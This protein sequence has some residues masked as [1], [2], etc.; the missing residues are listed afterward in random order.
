MSFLP[1][2]FSAPLA[3]IGLALLPVIYYLLR[4]T[5]PRPRQIPFPPLKLI[6]DIEPKDETPA[7]TPWWL[8]ALRLAIAALIVLAMAGPIWNPQ[9]GGAD[10]KEPLLVLLDDSWA[11]APT[12]EQRLKVAL[13]QVD[14]AARQGAPTAVVTASEG[15]R[16][17]VLSDASHTAQKLRALK[18]VPFLPDRMNLVAPIE[19]FFTEHPRGHLTWISD[20]LASGQTRPFAEKLAELAKNGEVEIVNGERSP[21]ALAGAANEASVLNVNVL[22]A[23]NDGPQQGRVRALDL[24]GVQIG[25][26]PFAFGNATETQARFDLPIE[27][28]NDIARLEIAGER[29]AGAVT[30]LDERWKRRRVGIVSGATADVAQPLLAPSYYLQRALQPFADVRE[31]RPGIADPIG[32]LLDDNVNVMVLAD[33]GVVAGLAHD[34]LQSFIEDGGA[35]VRFA[36]TRLAGSSDDLVPVALRRGG[37]TLGGSLSWDTPKKLAPFDR[38]SPF[39]GLAVPDEVTV[40]RQVL[41]E[42]EAGLPARTWAALADGTPLVT[43]E[44]QGK[45]MLVLFHVT[46]DTTWSNLPLSGLFVDMLRKILAISADTGKTDE[47][48]TSAAKQ[49]AATLAPLS[50]LDGFGALGPPPS[51][52]KPIPANFTDV[53][54]ADH[55]PGFYGPPDALVAVNP[56]ALDAKLQAADFSGLNFRREPL[57]AGEP[58]DL[59]PW[60]IA[61][62]I[63]LLI[64]DALASLFLSGGVPLRRQRRAAIAGLVALFAFG[65]ATMPSFV[66]PARAE[67]RA[68]QISPRDLESA[69]TTRL[70]YVVTGDAQADEA[71]RAG[72][73]SLTRALA[74][75][76]SLTPGDPVGVDPARDELVFYPLIYWPVVAGKPLPPQNAINKI[77]T[78]MKQGGTII[79]DTRDALASRPGGPMTPEARWLRDLLAGVDVPELEPVPHDHVITKTFYLLDGFIGRTTIGQTWIE[80]LP[81]EPSDGTPRPARAGDSVS[82]I[83]ITSN[84]LA[85]AWAADRNG[86]PLYP[87]V[88]GGTRQRELAIRGG[89]NLAIYTLTG[90]YKS[91][92]VH[93]RDLLDRLGH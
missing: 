34:R 50:T 62:V 10:G 25:D 67:E 11:A 56:L 49:Q 86:E 93:V 82:P 58:I 18:P 2:A 80:A 44:R 60:L 48:A 26:A 78:F 91:D 14:D 23:T 76:T 79:F 41:A 1:L 75:R 68:Q 30:L 15:A 22:R 61:A 31:A 64:V 71:S 21:L 46:A 33:V 29:S 40:S 57:N 47:D 5:P 81:P 7:R 27:L 92:V 85:A 12:W 20:G 51:T 63:A 88:P 90:N 74:A 6:L 9:H 36:G 39:F 37:R 38:T 69:L 70:A 52:A 8:L 55:P 3:L 59:R 16:E 53:A 83:V 89:I 42:P 66:V 84:D 65:T 32:A 24:K 35:L 4:I 87:L 54:G 19:H 13:A 45:G 17:A 73:T 77:A 43:A 72:L 28:R